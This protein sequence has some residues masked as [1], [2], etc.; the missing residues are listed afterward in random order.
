MTNTDQQAPTATEEPQETAGPF[1]GLKDA[2][3]GLGKTVVDAGFHRVG[4][5][6]DKLTTR[7][8]DFAD[9]KKEQAEQADAPG[10]VANA[11]KEAVVAKVE[12]ENPASAAIKGALGGVKNK[13]FGGGKGGKGGKGGQLK[14][15][16]IVEWIDVGVPV[17]V[18]YNQWTEFESWPGFMKKVENVQRNEEQGKL[19]FKAQVF[20]LHR[21]WEQ[22]II[23]M[24]PDD[25]IVWQS[26]GQKGY[27]NGGVTFHEVGDPP[28]TRICVVLEYHPQGVLEKTLNIWR[29]VGR[30]SRRELK[31]YVR[32]VQ[33]HT[34][35]APDEV[36]GWRAE[37][38]DKKIVRTH[39]EVVEQEQRE[40]EEAEAAEQ[41]EAEEEAPQGAE[42]EYDEDEFSEDE[43][44]SEP[45]VSE[46]EAAAAEDET[47]LG[48][49]GVGQEQQPEDQGAE[50]EYTEDE[51]EYPEEEGA[52]EERPAVQAQGEGAEDEGDY[53]SEE[54]GAESEEEGAE[55]E[56]D[57]EPAAED[58]GDYEDEE[59]EE[60]AEDE[61]ED[62]GEGSEDEYEDEESEEGAEDEYE[63]EEEGS[64]D[65]YEDE[66]EGEEDRGDGAGSSSGTPTPRDVASGSVHPAESP[67]P[68][69]RQPA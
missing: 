21:S 53:E 33:T 1:D 42:G 25:H 60:G 18:A 55:S 50:G 26:T 15:T 2:V 8:G 40:A 51:G 30:A 37:V 27:I 43:T 4:G 46:E 64:E 63:S 66:G 3:R 45:G 32:Q 7:L 57:E 5:L 6:T 14:F 38:R 44:E 19:A 52:E 24:V 28:M 47:Y 12:G 54:E 59:S 35:L 22:N 36:Q 10:P 67:R 17:R 11:V 41:Q 29:A 65:E 61:Y 16:N 48:E 13:L 56:G 58:E 20:L 31:R 39:D 49:A 9:G 69:R 34:I 23:E 62:E 68:R